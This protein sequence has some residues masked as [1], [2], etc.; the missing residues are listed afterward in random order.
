MIQKVGLSFHGDILPVERLFDLDD[1]RR[2]EVP[3]V[4]WDAL[5]E[6]EIDAF[7]FRLELILAGRGFRIVFEGALSPFE[8]QSHGSRIVV[9][10]RDFQLVSTRAS[11]R[12]QQSSED[13]LAFVPARFP[14]PSRAFHSDTGVVPPH[15]FPA[16]PRGRIRLSLFSA[17]TSRRS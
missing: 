15:P 9:R 3:F 4:V 12:R 16:R 11:P 17:R 5:F 6:G 1:R 7:R 13:P 10:G 8:A 14:F 2:D